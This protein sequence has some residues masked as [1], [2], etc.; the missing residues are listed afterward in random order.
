M[1]T[2][3]SFDHLDIMARTIY[4]E[5]RGLYPKKQGGL[6]ALI[7]VANVIMNRL[8]AQTWY[9][10]DIKEVCLKP[11]QFSCWNAQDPNRSVIER[12]TLQDS[13]FRLCHRVARHV[14]DHAWP[15]LTKGSDHYYACWLKKQPDW[16]KGV[17]PKVQ[18]SDHLFFQLNPLVQS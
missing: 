9:G 3:Y 4:G 13:L 12:I 7:S 5:A 17:E 18:I 16:A 14:A 15:D 6:S 10:F 2:S 11:Y 1:E 8:R